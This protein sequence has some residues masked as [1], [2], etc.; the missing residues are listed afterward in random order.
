MMTQLPPHA[1]V[2]CFLCIL[3]ENLIDHIYY[4][5]SI[6]YSQYFK[7]SVILYMLFYTFLSMYI[8]SRQQKFKYETKPLFKR[9][10]SCMLIKYLLPLVLNSLFFVCFYKLVQAREHLELMVLFV[11]HHEI[12]IF[13]YTSKKGFLLAKYASIRFTQN[14]EG[15]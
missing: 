7:N 1:A 14:F 15:E 13:S 12:M 4:T 9:K 5:N 6:S 2:C 10:L 3:P 8:V 11:E